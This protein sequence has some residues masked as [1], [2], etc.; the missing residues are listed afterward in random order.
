GPSAEGCLYLLRIVLAS[1]SLTDPISSSA[2]SLSQSAPSYLHSPNLLSVDTTPT[3]YLPAVPHPPIHTRTS[4]LRHTPP[5]TT[6]PPPHASTHHY[7]TSTHHHTPPHAS[8]LH[9]TTSTPHY[10]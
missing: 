10:N 8:T 7:T 4:L 5:H 2:E 3:A 6:T 1:A 9:Y